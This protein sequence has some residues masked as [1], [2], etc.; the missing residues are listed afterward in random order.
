MLAEIVLTSAEFQISFVKQNPEPPGVGLGDEV[1]CMSDGGFLG[2]SKLHH[3]EN[4]VRHCR[5]YLGVG[6][7]KERR[8][9][10]NDYVGQPAQLLVNGLHCYGIEELRRVRR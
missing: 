10:K 4:A 7:G 1:P 5:Q 9:V 2:F 6:G 8:A 3:I